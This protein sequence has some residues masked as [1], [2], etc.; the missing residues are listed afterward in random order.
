MTS[1]SQSSSS[2]NPDMQRNPVSKDNPQQSAFQPRTSNNQENQSTSSKS[3]PKVKTKAEE[4]NESPFP[5]I[6]LEESL[7]A[8]G[9]Y[10]PIPEEEVWQWEAPSRPFK[11]HNKKYF[12]TVAVIALL[13]S[14]ILGFAGQL[15]AVTVVISLTFVIYVLS[16][17]P[18]QNSVYKITTYGIRIDDAVYYWEELGYFWFDQKYDQELLNVEVARFPGRLTL[19]L[20]DQNKDMLKNILSEVLINKK[21]ELTLYEKTSAWL[22][23]K[24]PLDLDEEIEKKKTKK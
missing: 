17:V 18:P 4:Y 8:P 14:L 2:Q 15:V 19:L 3:A 7:L 5:K 24:I 20:A 22:Q 13:I 23:K 9:M 12:S 6:E 11:Q 10:R 1:Q 21:P 16:V